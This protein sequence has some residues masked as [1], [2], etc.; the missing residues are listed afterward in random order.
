MDVNDFFVPLILTGKCSTLA[1][2][3]YLTY[4]AGAAVRF[5][6]TPPLGMM[7]INT[8]M[9][10][11]L[12]DAVSGDEV[13]SNLYT[14]ENIQTRPY[15]DFPLPVIRQFTKRLQETLQTFGVNR[16][17]FIFSSN[18]QT[19]AVTN[20]ETFAVVADITIWVLETTEALFWSDIWPYMHGHYEYY[21]AYCTVKKS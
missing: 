12:R 18:P 8:G 16:V 5:S 7:W 4:A 19:Y 13:F 17:T 14:S 15:S 20:G 9:Y 10:M 1:S 6:I 3:V 2:Q 11:K 21:K